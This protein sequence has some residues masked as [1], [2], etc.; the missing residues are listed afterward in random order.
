MGIAQFFGGAK[1]KQTC[2]EK[3]TQLWPK[4]KNGLAR[5]VERSGIMVHVG[6]PDVAA[7][8]AGQGVI[9]GSD[10]DRGAE[11][12]QQLEHTVAQI[13]QVPAS[14]A[15]EAVKGAVV[16]ELGRVART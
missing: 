1:G 14:L 5:L 16:L 8:L 2:R 3:T 7:G 11:G 6:A 9:D 4:E 15:E 12:Q 10:Q 13:I